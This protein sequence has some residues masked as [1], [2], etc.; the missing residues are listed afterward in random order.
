MIVSLS[1]NCF[2]LLILM[3]R[4]VCYLKFIP[5]W[6]LVGFPLSRPNPII[7]SVVTLWVPQEVCAISLLGELKKIT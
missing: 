7:A 3:E 5:R 6:N 2:Y 1:I 4:I